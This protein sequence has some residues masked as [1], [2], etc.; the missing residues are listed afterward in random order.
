MKPRSQYVRRLPGQP[1]RDVHT[2]QK[3]AFTKKVLIWYFFCSKGVGTIAV[4]TGTMNTERYIHTL[5]QHL[6]PKAAEWFPEGGWT[7]IHDNAPCHKSAG[8]RA[9]LAQNGIQCMVW[10]PYSPDMNAI[11]NLWAILKEKVTSKPTP[12]S[13]PQLQN[14]VHTIWHQEASIATAC[15]TLA[16]SMPRRVLEVIRNRGAATH[17]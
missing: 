9:F 11:E 5:Q 14:L 13:I 1:I 16:K 2:V 3:R 7:F 12:Q 6:L 10:P 17:Y 15:D 8:T 4:I